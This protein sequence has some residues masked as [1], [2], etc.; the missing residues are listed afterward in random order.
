MEIKH[1]LNKIANV[2]QK[3]RYGIL[4]LFL[5]IA[6]MTI[7]GKD[8]EDK[9]AEPLVEQQVPIVSVESKLSDIL[10]TVAGAGKTT[11]FLTEAAGE[12]MIYQT[13]DQIRS[14]SETAE[15][16]TETI[17]VT[18]RNKDTTGLVRQVIPAQ[19]LGAIVVCQG[20]EN[21]AVKLAIVDAVSKVTGLG[22]DRISVLKMK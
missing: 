15:T 16:K 1:F 17:T 5:G 18:D 6:L 11:V 8:T 10:S 21:P 22:A 9:R 14:D 13:D 4:V 20:A 12:E 19:Y 7:P 3:Y 2:I